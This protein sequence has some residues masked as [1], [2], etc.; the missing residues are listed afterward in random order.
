MLDT[1]TVNLPREQQQRLHP[2]F[3]V[4]EQAYLSMRESLLPRY[5][6]QWVAVDQGT[7]VAADDD[8]TTV[9]NAVAGGRGRP[10]V[11]R[12]GAEDRVIFRVR[13][14]E[15][16]YD[17][18][19]QPFAL[20]K[21]TVT[22]SNGAGTRSQTYHDVIPDTGAD[23][24]MLPEAD[25]TSFDLFDS[26]YF[27]GL[28]AGVVGPRLT[29]LIYRGMAQVAGITHPAFIQAAREGEE[30]ILGRDV[31]NQRRVLFDGPASLTIV[32]P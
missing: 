23:V 19:Y 29:T 18:E 16:P 21:I 27:T 7:I 31:L 3:L 14:L 10:Y 32:D 25:C 2:E 1:E 8:L 12:V 11:A 26:P 17:R 9:M 6:G 5:S 15:F 13:R 4:N 24:S 30:R 22:F 28:S 20:P